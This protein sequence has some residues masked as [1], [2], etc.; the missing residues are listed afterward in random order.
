M[1]DVPLER[2]LFGGLT[3]PNHWRG[4]GGVTP[5]FR[6]SNPDHWRMSPV[7]GQPVGGFLSSWRFCV[8]LVV[9]GLGMSDI[10]FD[11]GPGSRWEGP[12]DIASW[13]FSG[14]WWTWDTRR[15]CSWKTC[16]QLVVTRSVGGLV[17][18]WWVR[19]LGE[20]PLGRW[21]GRAGGQVP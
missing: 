1:L 16:S 10:G 11:L 19:G 4:S 17:T 21:V 6:G 9:Q 8:Q 12:L 7:E 3:N 2:R 15:L 5:K 13:R 14:C 20:V 18:S